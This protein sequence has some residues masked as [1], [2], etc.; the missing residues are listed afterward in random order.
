M[1]FPMMSRL[2]FAVIGAGLLLALAA[3]LIASATGSDRLAPR[4]PWSVGGSNGPRGAWQVHTNPWS[5]TG[6]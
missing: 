4:G 1:S 6:S 5:V 2:R 3:A